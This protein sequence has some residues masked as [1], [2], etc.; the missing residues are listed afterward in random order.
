MAEQSRESQQFSALYRWLGA[1][2]I[3]AIFVVT[4]WFPTRATHF[5]DIFSSLRVDLPL[6]TK[7]TLFLSKIVSNYYGAALPVMFA[8][9]W[10]YFGWA[11]KKQER[12]VWFN[13]L[14]FLACVFLTLT[15]MGGLFV[16]ELKILDAL[17][18]R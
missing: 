18:K 15:V 16:P 3:F 4:A 8:I 6:T 5:K 10:L 17:R 7:F 13:V 2:P 9:C 12:M 11:A 1:V 14:A